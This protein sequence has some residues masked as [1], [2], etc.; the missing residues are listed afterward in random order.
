MR[1][2]GALTMT[3]MAAVR[4]HGTAPE[5]A[6]RALLSE[7]GLHYRLNVRSLP[8]SPDIVNQ[9]R[10][11]AVFVH[12][13]FWHHHAGCR[14]ATLPKAN[15]RFWL[16]KFAAN[17]ERDHRSVLALR[18]LGFTVIIV[19][20]CEVAELARLRKRLEALVGWPEGAHTMVV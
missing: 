8:G 15:R 18:R 6:V 20:E 7:F 9:R 17:K 19:W 1:R 12:G 2:P 3:R 16:A 14:R 13:C 11:I 5:L 4:Q 10:R